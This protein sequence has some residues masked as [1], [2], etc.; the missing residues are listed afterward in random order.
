MLDPLLTLLMLSEEYK[1]SNLV[2]SF[3]GFKKVFETKSSTISSF[4]EASAFFNEQ[5]V[6]VK[7]MKWNASDTMI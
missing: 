4:M 5:T 1:L 6:D 2:A 3:D 7:T